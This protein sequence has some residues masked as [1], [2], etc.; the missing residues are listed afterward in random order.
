MSLTSDEIRG[1]IECPEA[2]VDA[3]LRRKKIYFVDDEMDYKQP[4]LF[5]LW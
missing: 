1:C 5:D 2:T 3:I 4:T